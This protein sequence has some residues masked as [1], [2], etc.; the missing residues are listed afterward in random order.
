MTGKVGV[1]RSFEIQLTGEGIRFSGQKL[2]DGE[3]C[4]SETVKRS[5]AK[6]AWASGLLVQ[7][8]NCDLRYEK[9]SA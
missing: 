1:H 3:C 8:P 9:A 5:L 7:L 6:G 4:V 2:Q